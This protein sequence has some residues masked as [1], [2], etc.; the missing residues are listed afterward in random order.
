M[1]PARA[2]FKNQQPSEARQPI[3]Y[4][5]KPNWQSHISNL[6]ATVQNWNSRLFKSGLILTG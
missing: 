5:S 6:S 2:K 4:S 3:H 1:V